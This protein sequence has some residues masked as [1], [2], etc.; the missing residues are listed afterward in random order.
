MSGPLHPNVRYLADAGLEA[1]LASEGRTIPAT[2]AFVLLDDEIGRERVARHYREQAAIAERH[3]LGFI[4]EAPT[5]RA[6]TDWGDTVGYC[7]AE[8]AAINRKGVELCRRIQ[9]EFPALASVVAGQV[10]PRNCEFEPGSLMSADVAAIYH[11]AQIATLKEAGA[12][13]IMALAINDVEEAVGIAIAARCTK[14]ACAISFTTDINGQL[15]S[16]QTLSSAVEEVDARTDRA[17]AFFSVTCPC[18]MQWISSLSSTLEKR[19]K[20]VRVGAKRSRE[21]VRKREAAREPA[22]LAADY[23][24]VSALL[25]N[26]KVYGGASGSVGLR[27]MPARRLP[28][29]LTAFLSYAAV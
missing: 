11:R 19:I 20:A 27:A 6:S 8:L 3:G 13:L 4:F 28:P 15:P 25:P 24:A 12:D 1:K 10:G 29:E 2:A 16:G 5:W 22:A 23:R 26:L 14:I 18:P 17:P 21:F 7:E 9:R